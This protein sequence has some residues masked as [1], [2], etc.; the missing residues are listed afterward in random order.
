MNWVIRGRRKM[1]PEQAIE[2]LKELQADAASLD[3]DPEM[4]HGLAD[5]V[6]CDL[7]TSLGHGEVAKAF[8]DI[9]PRWYG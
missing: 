4:A 7:L 6:L 2:R 1:N 8:D 9:I 5:E 3:G